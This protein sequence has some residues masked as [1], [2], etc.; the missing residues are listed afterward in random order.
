MQFLSG[1]TAS[2]S[3][4]PQGTDDQHPPREQSPDHADKTPL[5]ECVLTLAGTHTRPPQTLSARTEPVR[6]PLCDAGETSY[7]SEYNSFYFKHHYMSIL[8][9]SH[10]T[11]LYFSVLFYS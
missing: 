1:K 4:G 10:L 11:E 2:R 7:V 8:T 5:S 6:Q 3:P 9:I